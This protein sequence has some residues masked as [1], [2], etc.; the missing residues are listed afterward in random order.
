MLLQE[1]S[2][3]AAYVFAPKSFLEKKLF[4]IREIFK[5]LSCGHSGSNQ[6]DCCCLQ[7]GCPEARIDENVAKLTAAGYKVSMDMHTQIVWESQY[8]VLTQ[9]A[10][11]RLDLCLLFAVPFC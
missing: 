4:V 3:N 8:C 1:H 5:P 6:S 11:Q 7:V 2:M 9:H 10:H